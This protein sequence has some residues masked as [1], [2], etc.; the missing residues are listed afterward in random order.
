MSTTQLNITRIRPQNY[1][2]YYY[3]SKNIMG[4][5]RAGFHLR[6]ISCGKNLYVMRSLTD[7]KNHIGST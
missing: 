2:E 1:D 5:A 7:V 3:V 6:G 4:I